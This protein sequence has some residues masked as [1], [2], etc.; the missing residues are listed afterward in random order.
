MNAKLMF[1][2]IVISTL[3]FACGNN[4]SKDS[5]LV[6]DKIEQEPGTN[7]ILEAK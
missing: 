7:K 5:M 2:I 6:K 4:R 3:L 1:S